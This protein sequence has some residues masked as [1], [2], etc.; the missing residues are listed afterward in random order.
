MPQPTPEQYNLMEQVW[1]QTPLCTDNWLELNYSQ[2]ITNYCPVAALCQ[3][4]T[5]EQGIEFNRD[6]FECT[7]DEQGID[8]IWNVYGPALMARFGITRAHIARI[9][10]DVDTLSMEGHIPDEP[11]IR[12][13]AENAVHNISGT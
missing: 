6:V 12:Q 13:T 7:A 11:L 10:L 3:F 9:V 5:T 4:V 8:G 1:K 2:E